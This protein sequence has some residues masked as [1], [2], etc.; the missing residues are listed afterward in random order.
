MSH[1]GFE[2]KCVSTLEAVD[3]SGKHYHNYKGVHFYYRKNH[4]S[5]RLIVTFN[6]ATYANDIN[7]T[8][9]HF[10][11]FKQFIENDEREKL[12]EKIIFTAFSNEE[13]PP[14]GKTHHHVILPTGVS[15]N[16]AIDR[17]FDE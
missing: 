3:G 5:D 17:L 16:D 8:N 15:M 11:P 2:L 13:E 6:G 14:L 1:Y 10:I 9:N 12:K 7:H 4:E